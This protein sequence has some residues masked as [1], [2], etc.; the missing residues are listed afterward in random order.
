[1]QL[2]NDLYYRTSW[3][4][5]MFREL[6]API[7]RSTTTVCAA[8]GTS[9]QVRKSLKLCHVGRRSSDVYL[10]QWL[11]IQLFYSW[12]WVQEAPETCRVFK[13]CSNKDHCPAASCWFIKYWYVMHGTMNLKLNYTLWV[14]RWQSDG[15]IVWTSIISELYRDELA[16]CPHIT[17]LATSTP[18]SIHLLLHVA[19]CVSY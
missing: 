17:D 13:K 8:S 11:H 7:I 9:T 18:L 15:L 6:L 4:L 12:W 3:L 16:F 2:D 1:M 14:F 19:I 5:Y 10:C